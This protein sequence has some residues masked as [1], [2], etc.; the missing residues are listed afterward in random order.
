MKI[1]LFSCLEVHLDILKV[2]LDRKHWSCA[3]AI[4]KI[5]RE[6]F[7]DAGL[8][9]FNPH[10]FRN[11]LTLLGQTFCRNA[12]DLKAWSQN[13]G[14]EKVLTTFYSYGEVGTARQGEIIKG[15]AKP[16][17]S[18]NQDVTQLAK[19]IAQEMRQSENPG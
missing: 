11:T 5:F 7:E 13:I 6:A 12:E 1:G 15:L 18:L 3:T 19:A 17:P 16:Q 9:Y 14:H 2:G 10:S 8:T 4:R